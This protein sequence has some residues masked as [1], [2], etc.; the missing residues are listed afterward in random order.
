VS[1]RA[2]ERSVTSRAVAEIGWLASSA[3]PG[4]GWAARAGV[5]PAAIA[6]PTD[7][8]ASSRN[9]SFVDLVMGLLRFGESD[10]RVCIARA[11]DRAG[12]PRGLPRTRADTR[13]APPPDSCPRRDIC[14]S[15]AGGDAIVSR[16][17]INERGGRAARVARR[18]KT[19]ASRGEAVNANTRSRTV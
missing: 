11:S 2:I 9:V 7:V 12:G 4:L 1:V 16:A 15:F 18:L 19:W 17:S 6:A 13:R 10:G 3:A 8:S 14:P 5:Q